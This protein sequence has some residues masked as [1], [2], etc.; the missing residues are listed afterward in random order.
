MIEQEVKFGPKTGLEAEQNG[1]HAV[2]G[3]ASSDDKTKP[4]RPRDRVHYYG[5]RGGHDYTQSVKTIF[6][7]AKGNHTEFGKPQDS[8]HTSCPQALYQMK[9]KTKLN[10]IHQSVPTKNR[11]SIFNQGNL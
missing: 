1:E 9:Q 8:E 7:L 3:M 10:K 4:S 6:M 5:P 2:L 11:F